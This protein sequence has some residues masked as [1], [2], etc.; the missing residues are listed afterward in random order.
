MPERFINNEIYIFISKIIFPAF[1]AV[2]VKLA[3][4]MRKNKAKISL[5][6]ISLSMIIGVGG[7]YIFSGLVQKNCDDEYIPMVIALIAM[8]AEKIG[9]FII[10]KL[11]IDKVLTSLVD[12]FFDTVIKNRNK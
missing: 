11:N 1:L 6:N 5:L 3:I 2:G 7:A 12:T 10:Y 8:T 9:E 4:E